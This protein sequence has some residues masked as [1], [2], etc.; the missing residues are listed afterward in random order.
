[1]RSLLA[2]LALPVFSP[3]LAAAGSSFDGRWV[4]A[5]EGA[6]PARY[7]W[8]KVESEGGLRGEFFGVTGGRLAKLLDPAI[9]DQELRFR[10][11]REF[12]GGEKRVAHT[13]A[14]RGGDEIHGETRTAREV[15]KW[16][17]WPAPVVTDRDDGAWVERPPLD[18]FKGG[19]AGWRTLKPGNEGGWALEGGT[20]ASRAGKA[21][22]LVSRAEFWNFVLRLEFRLPRNGNAGIGLRGRYELQLFD[23]Y[24]KPPD[25][26]GNGS[27]YSRIAPTRNASRPAGQWQTL[28]VRLVGRDV[29]V[30]L[31]GQKV[32]DRRLIE[33]LCGLPLDLHEDKPGPLWLQ[34]DHG[35]VEYRNV[36]MTRL[37]RNRESR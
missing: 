36:I 2:S 14:R 24:G 25:A 32:I 37:E 10:V 19:L 22:F 7:F 16:R 13:T 1:M 31:N 9:Q 26:L 6:Q 20:L 18:L 33:G 3:L 5:V 11:E 28:E 4:I 29:T 15:L 8:L 35:P 21:D 23:D 30:T 17:G 34:G 12:D 27:I